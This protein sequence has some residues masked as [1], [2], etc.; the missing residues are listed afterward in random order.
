[1]NTI[2]ITIRSWAAIMALIASVGTPSTVLAQNTD[3]QST[4]GQIISRD[5][6]VEAGDTLRSIAQREFGKSGL[7]WHLA[8]FNGL[9]ESAQLTAGQTLRIP[10]IVPVRPEFARVAFSKGDVT[11]DG[12][13]LSVDDRIY[14]NDTLVTGTNGFVSLVFESGSVVNLQ[15]NSAAKLVRLHCLADDDQ[16]LI[17]VQ[18]DV[19]EISSDVESSDNQSTDFRITTPFASAAVRGTSLDFS[20]NVD[21]MVVGVTEGEVSLSAEGEQVALPE[22]FGSVANAGQPPAQPIPLLPG[23]VYRYIPSRA[24]PGDPVRWWELT[25]VNQ[26]AATITRDE[27]GSEVIST[28]ES[29]ANGIIVSDGIA[30]GDYFVRVR[31]IDEN[32]IKGN[33][34]SSRISVAAID[35]SLPSVNT[36]IERQGN[37]Y[38]VSVVDPV[39]IAQ[40]YEIQVS[41]T[42]TFDDPLSVDISSI[43]AAVFRL[44]ERD[45][46][47]ARARVLA[48]PRTV[49]AYGAIASLDQ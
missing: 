2:R 49:S 15:P 26:Y 20:A 16:C 27:Q 37:E 13:E 47:F 29:D 17:E 40:G 6:V 4:A 12:S 21:K 44:E 46:L 5:I 25:A 33:I 30:P 38:V 9:M 41:D 34:T 32:G 19:G 8:E 36:S 23:P 3:D 14:L 18:A 22:G 24:A 1:M 7:A 11:R 42:E 43:G 28:F 35:A 39:D 31:A 48:D 45:E 10:L